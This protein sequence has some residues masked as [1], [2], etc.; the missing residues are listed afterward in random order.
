MADFVQVGVAGELDHRWRSTHDDER[1]IAGGRQ[2][3]PHHV[4]VDEPLAVLPVCNTGKALNCKQLYIIMFIFIRIIICTSDTY[5]SQDVTAKVQTLAQV[6][7]FTCSFEV[8]VFWI[9]FLCYYILHFT[10][11]Y[12]LRLKTCTCKMT[13]YYYKDPQLAQHWEIETL[14]IPDKKDRILLTLIY[15]CTII[16]NAGL[17]LGLLLL[18]FSST[19]ITD[20]SI[21]YF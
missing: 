8:I 14:I 21:S 7:T 5:W 2:V 12:I 1:V 4:L 3:V 9:V 20:R 16:L 19:S 15:F 13:F 10:V 17:L 11:P 6:R 18:F